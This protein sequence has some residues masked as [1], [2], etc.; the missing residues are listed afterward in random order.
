MISAPT[1]IT[2]AKLQRQFTNC[3]QKR[4]GTETLPYKLY[5]IGSMRAS[6][7]TI[8]QIARITEKDTIIIS[9]ELY[10]L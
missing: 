3:P 4:E 7:P 10:L 2:A 5:F 8:K 1:I 6:T 9:D